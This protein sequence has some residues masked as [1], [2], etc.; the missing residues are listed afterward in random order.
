[1]KALILIAVLFIIHNNVTSQNYVD[2]LKVTGN[3]TSVNKFDTSSSSTKINEIYADLTVPIKLNENS[4]LLSGVIYENIQTKLFEDGNAITLNSYTLKLGMNKVFNEK[5]SGTAVLLPK[6]SS[7]FVNVGNKDFQMGGIAIIKFKKS[8]SLNY[9]F[10]MYYNTDLFGPFFVPMVGMYYLS[11][12]KKFETNIML[13]LQA[14][15]NYK[16]IPF[17]NIGFNFNGQIRSYHLT[18][19]TPTIHSAYVARST[20][21]F[22]AYLKF[23]LSK[24]LSIQTKVGQ[25]LGRSYRVYDE[26]D[27]VN[28]CLPA[29][30]IGPKRHQ[31]NTNF[32]NGQIFQ[33]TLLYRINLEK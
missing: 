28:F 1:M 27:K 30:F 2:F 22:F 26:N 6:L 13:P 8:S 20:N 7:D 12:N 10:G 21:E 9:K 32:A 29:T 5:W 4:C 16:I 23:N 33:V 11:P 24:S 17:M 3:T 18:D 15:V 19:I 14:D 25:S 31:L